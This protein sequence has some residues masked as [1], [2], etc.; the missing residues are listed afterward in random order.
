VTKSTARPPADDTK[1]KFASHRFTYVAPYL[2]RTEAGVY[3]GKIKRNGKIH[4]KSLDTS[5]FQTA[6]INLKE[7]QKEVE[8]KDQTAP[9]MLFQDFAA[10]WLESVKPHLKPNT[11]RRKQVSVNKLL[12]FLKG[13]KMREIKH[14][15]LEK[16]VKARSGKAAHTFNLDREALKMIFAYANKLKIMHGENPVVD[17]KK[18]KAIKAVIV[19][20]TREQFASL[21]NA[22]NENKADHHK[23]APTFVEF[24]AYTGMRLEEALNVQWRHVSFK[25][26]GSILVTGGETGTKNYSQRSIP[27]FPRAKEFLLRLSQGKEMPALDY[28]FTHKS[29]KTA[30]KHASTM[31][32]LPKGEHFTHHDMRHYF[33]SNALEKNVPDHVI[34]SWL[35]HKD[36][37]ILVRKTYGHLRASHSTEMAKLMD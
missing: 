24:L 11:Y 31:I 35:G 34:A 18:R 15:H 19:P 17:I 8:T 13:W 2:Y 27:M 9:D 36:G 14:A 16:W 28:L 23:D 25:G 22:M 30:L 21:L 7:F 6:K 12:P 20:P 1:P 32:G 3:Y 5:D 4:Q 33:C 26:E 37:G 29:S 10:Q